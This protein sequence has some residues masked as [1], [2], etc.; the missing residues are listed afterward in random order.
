MDYRALGKYIDA[1]HYNKL[2]LYDVPKS[3]RTEEFFANTFYYTYDYIKNNIEKFDRNFFKDLIMTDGGSLIFDKNCFEIMPIEY[4][5]EE[6]VSSH[7]YTAGQPDP[8]FIIR[9]SG[10]KRLSNFLTW[11][12]AYSE[13]WFSDIMWPAFTKKHLME[14]IE[15]YQKRNRRFGAL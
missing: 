7:I 10:E 1:I 4:I 3:L 13:F 5:D 11:Q 8:D 12:S 15:E 2:S 9:P 14:A 6:M